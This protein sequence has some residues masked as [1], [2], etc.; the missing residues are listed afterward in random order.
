MKLNLDPI[1]TQCIRKFKIATALASKN[2]LPSLKREAIIWN[3]LCCYTKN[4]DTGGARHAPASQRCLYQ[5][6]A[7][8]RLADL[9][10]RQE[11]NTEHW[12]SECQDL[13]REWE[14]RAM[15]KQVMV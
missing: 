13:I 12:K 15:R 9:K 10:K 11:K 4:N 7:L 1:R 5:K 14:A 3:I 8:K 6:I 2:P